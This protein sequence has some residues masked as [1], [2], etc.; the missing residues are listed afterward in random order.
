MSERYY[1][2]I[3]LQFYEDRAVERICLS[4]SRVLQ[5]RAWQFDDNAFDVSGRILSVAVSDAESLGVEIY[6]VPVSL[7]EGV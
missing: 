2:C 3:V 4:P 7:L 6:V 1:P 5:I